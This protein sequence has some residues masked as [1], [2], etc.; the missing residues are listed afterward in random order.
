M[1]HSESMHQDQVLSFA[2]T[3]LQPTGRPL[4]LDRDGNPLYQSLPFLRFARPAEAEALYQRYQQQRQTPPPTH[5]YPKN[6]VNN[7]PNTVNDNT[8]ANKSTNTITNINFHNNKS[9]YIAASSNNINNKSYFPLDKD[10]DNSD[11][12][13]CEIGNFT[14]D[15][16]KDSAEQTNNKDYHTLVD[17]PNSRFRCQACFDWNETT[18]QQ[19]PSRCKECHH[20]ALVSITC[21]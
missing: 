8:T 10:L 20:F 19:R 7:E 4:N 14:D 1:N 3:V 2:R 21:Y 17:I 12:D 6:T 11:N 15:E 9:A 16:S 18:G 13:I 5:N